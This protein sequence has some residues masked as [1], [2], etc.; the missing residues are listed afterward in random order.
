MK[1]VVNTLRAA[2]YR[3]LNELGVP[4]DGYPAP[5]A[6]AHRILS[7]AV[8]STLDE[9]SLRQEWYRR[10]FE[11]GRKIGSEEWRTGNVFQG[12]IAGPPVP[13]CS[14]DFRPSTGT[15]AGTTCRK[16]GR[17]EPGVGMH[18]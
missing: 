6:N 17:W 10:G 2:I 15:A 7:E 3:A 16:C 1:L 12:T 13:E 9:E 18:L 5:V 14:H 8:E 4:G 11:D